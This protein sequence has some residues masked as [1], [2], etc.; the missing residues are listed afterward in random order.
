MTR[1]LQNGVGPARP[2]GL[3]AL[4][5]AVGNGYRAALMVPTEILA[6]QLLTTL[7]QFLRGLPVKCAMLTSRLS[8]KERDKTVEA[9]RRGEVD[10]VV[11]THALLES[12]VWFP[13]LKFAVIDEQHRFGVRQRTTLRQKSAL[14]DLLVMTAT[15]IPRTLALALYGDLDVSTL[16][17]MPPNKTT[18]Q[19][20]HARRNRP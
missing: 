18:A 20:F 19:T 16:D 5:L 10:I 11:G 14:L 7:S 9:V 8:K 1:P 17:E 3:S 13:K 4:L 6:D 12:D 2:S 15:P